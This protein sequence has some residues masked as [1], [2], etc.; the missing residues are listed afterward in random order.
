MSKLDPGEKLE[1][2][3]E[4]VFRERLDAVEA[5]MSALENATGLYAS[6]K[7]IDSAKG[8]PSVKW[9][10]RSWRGQNFEGKRFSECSPKF[11]DAFADYLTW[12]GNNPKSTV[13]PGQTQEQADADAQK[14]AKWALIDAGRCRSWARR[15]RTGWKSAVATEVGD[16]PGVAPPPA[17]SF[18]APAFDAP[19]FDAPSADDDISF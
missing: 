15:L 3:A 6:D 16:F 8:D 17:A 7:D 18:D 1:T 12:K 11:L 2:Q 14:Y 5:R 19:S 4:R 9:P 13:K 10:P